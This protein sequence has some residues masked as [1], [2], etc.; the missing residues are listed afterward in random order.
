MTKGGKNEVQIRFRHSFDSEMV[1]TLVNPMEVDDGSPG[2]I[3]LQVM[4]EIITVSQ[5]VADIEA[6]GKPELVHHVFNPFKGIRESFDRNPFGFDS[7]I[8]DFF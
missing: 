8:Q 6:Y 1:R 4:P 5:N 7:V 3:A 2:K